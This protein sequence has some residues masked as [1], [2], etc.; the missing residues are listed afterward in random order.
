VASV[1]GKRRNGRTYYYLAESARVGGKPRIVSQRYLG[2]AEDIARA[3]D[4]GVAASPRHA[5]GLAFGDVAAV[6][7]TVDRIGLAELVDGIVG[8][9]RARVS[10][11]TYLALAVLHRATAPNSD[12]ARWWAGTAAER[13]VRPRLARAAVTGERCWRALGK[14]TAERRARIE[15]AVC[16]AV[17]EW[18]GGP[19]R[20]LAL[21][22]PNFATFDGGPG[23][24][25]YGLG[26]VVTMDGAIPLVS[27][28]YRRNRPGIASFGTLADEL[29]RAIPGPVTLVFD[30]GQY[31]QLDLRSGRHFVGALPLNE[32]PELLAK[33][34]SARRAV[35]PERFPGLTALDTRTTVAGLRRRVVLTHSPT[36]HAAQA[37]GFAQ[38]LSNATRELEGLAAALESGTYRHGREQVLT[39]IARITRARRVDRVL[40]IEVTGSRP[41]SI[42]LDWRIDESAMTRLDDEYFGK[43]LLVTDHDDWPVADVIAAYRARYY[44][45]STFRRLNEPFV[46][47]PAPRW[48]WTDERIELHALICVL[49]ATVTHLMRREADRAG[50]D[51][52]VRELMDKLAGIEETVLTYPSTG[53]RPRSHRLLTD[54]D[55]TQELLYSLFT[56]S[57]YA[58]PTL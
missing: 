17:G 38:A 43:Q 36:L 3:M 53:G 31:A 33:P 55:P 7:S 15:E 23:T 4:G 14:L 30:T 26:L 19:T 50:L 51:V 12:L 27:G 10:V 46:T 34:S 25:L 35:D 22:V 16:A 52:S 32:H 37:R 29:G 49:A 18:L 5:R 13:F 9:Q 42:R 44:L 20:A 57:T 1:I 56:L 28:G 21:D 11:G 24:S 48:N 54:L 58:P 6:W 47:G 40:P 39:E 41:G 2:T 45:D 8:P